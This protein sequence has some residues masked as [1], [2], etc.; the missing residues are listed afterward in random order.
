MAE[1]IWRR[2]A[3]RRD[4]HHT[5]TR[6]SLT[7]FGEL[8]IPSLTPWRERLSASPEMAGARLTSGAPASALYFRKAQLSD[9]ALERRRS[10]HFCLAAATLFEDLVRERLRA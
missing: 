4:W 1:P 7:R 8:P 3:L 5:A 9:V 2:G 6:P 10:C